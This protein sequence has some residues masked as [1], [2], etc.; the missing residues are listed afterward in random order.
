MMKMSS[1]ISTS[2]YQRQITDLLVQICHETD[3]EKLERLTHHL[4]TIRKLCPDY[5]HENQE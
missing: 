2:A 4:Q 1:E 5:T 3:P